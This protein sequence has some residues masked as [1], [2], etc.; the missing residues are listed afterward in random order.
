MSLRTTLL[1]A[2]KQA[3]KNKDTKQVSVLRLLLSDIKK[4]EIDAKK[5]L[6]DADIQKIIATSVKRLKDAMADFGKGGRQDLVDDAQ[7]EVDVLTVYL[8]A[9]LSDDEVRAIVTQV[10]A[11]LG[12]SSSDMGKVMGAVMAKVQGQADGRRVREMVS[13]VLAQE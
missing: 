11:D 5:E 7:Y 4:Q 6:T 1:E 10:A 12:A 9:Q 8:P 3:M 13:S 2:L